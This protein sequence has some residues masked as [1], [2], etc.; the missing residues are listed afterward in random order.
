[1]KFFSLTFYSEIPSRIMD[2]LDAKKKEKILI[3]FKKYLEK[4][5]LTDEEIQDVFDSSDSTLKIYY[6][7]NDSLISNVELALP[8]RFAKNIEIKIT[9]VDGS[10]KERTLYN[11]DNFRKIA[12]KVNRFNN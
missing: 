1:M 3:S 4:Y 10:T 2:K 12:K 8:S 5:E 11:L 7:Y 9:G 6:D